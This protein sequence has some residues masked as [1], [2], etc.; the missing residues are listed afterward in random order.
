MSILDVYDEA[1]RHAARAGV[2]PAVVVDGDLSRPAEIEAF[3]VL[4]A[5]QEEQVAEVRQI[6]VLCPCGDSISILDSYRC[7]KCDVRLCRVCA[8]RHFS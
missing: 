1:L 5:K 8:A 3:E 2:L 6:Q 7:L 4:V